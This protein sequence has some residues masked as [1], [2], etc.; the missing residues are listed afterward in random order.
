MTSTSGL[1][2]GPRSQLDDLVAEL[3]DLFRAGD[4]ASIDR[5]L[6]DH[7]SCSDQLRGLLPALAVLDDLGASAS[8]GVASPRSAMDPTA[9]LGV[10]GDFRIVREIGR[11]GMGVV[12]E[13]LQ[14]SLGRR[15]ALKV[16]PFAS[17]LDPRHL[18][19]FRIETQAAAVLHHPRIVPIHAVGC[20]RG[21]HYYAMQFIEG[22]TL[23]EVIDGLRA[24]LAGP[25]RSESATP[26]RRLASARS[27]A[28]LGL[29]A[30][31]A[32]EHAHALG[33]IHRDVKPANLILDDAGGLWVADFGLARLGDAVGPT[34]SDHLVGTLRYMAP[35]QAL[36]RGVG[37]DRQADVY[38]LGMTLYELLTLRPAFEAS[39]RRTLL[40]KVA[41]EEPKAPR[42]IDPSIPRDLETIVRKAIA[43]EPESRYPTAEEVAADLR[44]FLDDRPIKARRPSP[45]GLMARWSR[46]HRAAVLASTITL[47]AVSSAS[48]ILFWR[49]NRRTMEALRGAQ[50]ARSR[51][52]EALRL[53]FAGSDLIA[54]R[55]IRKIASRPSKIEGEDAEFCRKALGHYERVCSTHRGDP[56]ALLVVAAAEHRVGF[57]KG[58]LHLEGAE[59]RLDLA[60]QL[61][62]AGIAANPSDQ[63]ARKSLSETLDDLAIVVEMA[64]GPADAE[65]AR[66]QALRVRRDL[67]S[68]FPA[69][70]E[71][72]L[73]VALTLA[74][75]IAPLLD[76]GR[77][78]EAEA[79]REEL[80]ASTDDSLGLAPSES[81]L[82]NDLAWLLAA[83][84]GGS[85]RAYRRALGLARRAVEIA[86][87]DRRAWNTLGVAGYRAG[88]DREAVWALERSLVLR[89]GGD[90]YD[91]IFLALARR[92]LGETDRAR[93]LFER[94]GAWIAGRT[95]PDPDLIRFEAEAAETFRD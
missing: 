55:A 72:R 68:R 46:R 36:G 14:I 42:S 16:L 1:S 38:A 47:M 91:W 23:A 64:R 43:K 63:E 56:G 48:S 35:E 70:P 40:R 45:I 5:L 30:A 62:E 34:R 39:D 77:V 25:G 54:S 19:R 69:V 29:Q 44:R 88:D 22:R 4:F 59:P 58:I 90:P 73:S 93:A 53:T 86:P 13:A 2:T 85:S 6:N 82:R 31:E 24:E 87:E 76:L 37:G 21:V 20:D 94:S 74:Y 67:A 9:G 66:G 10:L 71:Y 65:A 28:T 27:A 51:E 11:G 60:V 32:L 33:V 52:H 57:L 81:P 83:R 15:V 8:S 84:R 26:R 49:E 3:T 80:A 18:A 92:R 50:A 17:A 79:A 41:F 89:D 7:P 95:T 12:Y 78:A 75:R 61:Y